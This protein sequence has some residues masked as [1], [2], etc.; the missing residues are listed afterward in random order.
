LAELN[1][2][3]GV[4][5]WT[6]E[7]VKNWDS[8]TREDFTRINVHIGIPAEIPMSEG[9]KNFATVYAMLASQSLIGVVKK[10]GMNPDAKVTAFIF[11]GKP[12]GTDTPSSFFSV[13]A[14][15]G[16]DVPD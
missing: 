10:D 15:L 11:R 12:K 9:L 6:V 2:N 14:M 7:R 1:E 13:D 16:L 5:W 8:Y 3:E 4:Q